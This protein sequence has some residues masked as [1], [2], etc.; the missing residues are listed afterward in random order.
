MV[1]NLYKPL[2]EAADR[3]VKIRVLRPKGWTLSEDISKRI[4]S[5]LFRKI[6]KHIQE[7]RI[8]QREPDTVPVFL[9]FNE[10]EVSALSFA[11]LDG[12][13]DYLAFKSKDSRSHKWCADLFNAIWN[14][15]P[16]GEV[17]VKIA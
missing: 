8:Q 4:N 1:M 9:A 5:D 13:L 7:G 16:P 10:K 15:S 17:R 2:Q 12:E 6:Y 14:N 11:K 3:G